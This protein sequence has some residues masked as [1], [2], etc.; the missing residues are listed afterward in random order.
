[1]A[2]Q[3]QITGAYLE[4]CNCEVACPC[5]FGTPP[6]PGTCTV[7]LGW[8]IDHGHFG[9]LTL[10]GLNVALAATIPGLP[11]TA[12]WTAGLYVDASASLA[13]QEALTAIF[14]GQAGGQPGALAGAIRQ[15]VGVKSVP[16]T[17]QAEGKRRH[18]QI[19]DIGDAELEACVDQQG[20]EVTIHNLPRW[21]SRGFPL[22][23]AK[24]T[25][26]HYR[27][28]GWTW[29]ISEKNGYYSPFRYAG[30]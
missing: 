15:L 10:D 16:I 12:P 19:A 6:P 29:E 7:L 26:V 8:H 30:S 5:V 20:S 2:E 3:W 9:P 24:S 28:H 1:M 27:D 11:A 4:A 13:Q 14:S 23:V 21:I 18:L 22:T 17:Y 25:R